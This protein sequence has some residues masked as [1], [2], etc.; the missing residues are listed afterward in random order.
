M[1]LVRG[2]AVRLQLNAL[3]CKHGSAGVARADQSPA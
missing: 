2:D 1:L 3:T